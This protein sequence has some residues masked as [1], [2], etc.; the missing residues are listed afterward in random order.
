MSTVLKRHSRGI[1]L[2]PRE[3]VLIGSTQIGWFSEESGRRLDPVRGG[4]RYSKLLSATK[5]V[6]CDKKSVVRQ[7]KCRH[8]KTAITFFL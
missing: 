2:K 1:L 7:K 5:K 4:Q 6:S 3:T 8:V